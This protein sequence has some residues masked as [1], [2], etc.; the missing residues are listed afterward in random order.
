MDFSFREVAYMSRQTEYK[1]TSDQIAAIEATVARGDR[2]EVVPVKDGLRL[3]RV[4]RSEIK[5]ICR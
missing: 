2:V 5:S 1:L 4:H 3:L